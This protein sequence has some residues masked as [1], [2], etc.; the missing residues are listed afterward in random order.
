MTGAYAT[1]TSGGSVTENGIISYVGRLSYNYKQRYYLQ[2]SVRRDGISKLSEAN[3]WN[4][5]T[6]YSAGWNIANEEFFSSLNST[7]NE[8][9]LRGSYSEVG[10]TEIGSYPY[11]GL[12][13]ASPYGTLNGIAFTQFGNDQLLWETSKK[14]DYGVDLSLLNNKIRPVSYTHLTLPTSD[15]V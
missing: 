9:K 6:G 13:S 4:N 8:F 3:R 15:L 14:T 12:T 10:N 7:I 5:F 2:G 11:L 1:Q